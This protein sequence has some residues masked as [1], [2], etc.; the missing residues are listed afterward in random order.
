MKYK[1]LIILATIFCLNIAATATEAEKQAEKAAIS[2]MA[3]VDTGQYNASW[4]EAATLFRESI[5]S[6]SW[7]QAVTAARK[8]FG[9]L[10]S[11]RLKVA[12]YAMTLPGAPDGEYV[13]MEFE[14]VYENK[15]KAIE[16]VTAMR[17]NGNW[18]VAGYYIR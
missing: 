18:N 9:K 15:A 5:T 7:S 6:E 1:I 10:M 13:V 17:D 4:K 14:A 2:W 11:R 8:P 16:T 3:L 12:N